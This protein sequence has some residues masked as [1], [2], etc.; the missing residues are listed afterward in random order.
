M[1]RSHSQMPTVLQSTIAAATKFLTA[2][3]LALSR[4]QS[5]FACDG[6]SNTPGWDIDVRFDRNS[7]DISTAELAKLSVWSNDMRNRFRIVDVVSIVGLAE[8]TERKPA[9]LAHRR[10]ANVKAALDQF[11]IRGERNSMIAR[12][13]KLPFPASE[14]DDTGR[15]VEITFGPG[16]PN[17]CCPNI[18]P[19]PKAQ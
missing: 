13:Y 12:I 4:P 3:T 8:L 1:R 19:L 14:F 7:S 11:S 2:V 10:A 9:I 16:C 5:A 6:P 18:N 15:R 17:H